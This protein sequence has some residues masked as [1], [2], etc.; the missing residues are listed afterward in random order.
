MY[1]DELLETFSKCGKSFIIR[2]DENGD[3]YIKE[4]NGKEYGCSYNGL[5]SVE[6][7]YL[8]STK[9]IIIRML[10]PN[11][12]IPISDI[13][14]DKYSIPIDLNTQLVIN[15]SLEDETQMYLTNSTKV[16]GNYIVGLRSRLLGWGKEIRLDQI[17]TV[18]I[19]TEMTYKRD[20][21]QSCTLNEVP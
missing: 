21:S 10:E 16:V 3:C 20:K 17:K 14:G 9:T 5:S 7:R 4:G 19:Y 6:K 15:K 13:N 8:D 11:T 2:I 18:E 12:T 1:K